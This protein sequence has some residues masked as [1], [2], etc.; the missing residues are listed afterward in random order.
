MNTST[1]P[2]QDNIP[3]LVLALK[4]RAL[5]LAATC[6]WVGLALFLATLPRVLRVPWLPA[7]TSSVAGHVGTHAVLA[8]LV[9]LA[10]RGPG[11]RPGGRQAALG[12]AFTVSLTLGLA[13]EVAQLALLTERGFELADIVDNLTGA[14]LGGLTVF[15][16]ETRGIPARRLQAGIGAISV[17]LISLA[18]VA[19]VVWDPRLPYR[20]D[21]WHALYSI[22]ICGDLLPAM[23]GTQGGVHTHGDGAIHIHPVQAAESGRNADLGL[24]F[25]TSGGELT[26][27]LLRLPGGRTVTNGDLCADGRPGKLSALVNGRQ[28][29]RPDRYVPRDRDTIEV[30]FG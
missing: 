9:Y 21:H 12:A 20:G 22:R 6:G 15:A 13:L 27:E 3:R 26:N 11:G 4:S 1:D 23:A 24:F 5:I 16:L 28:V 29:S 8:A 14:A 30:R 2:G 19:V 18:S 10:V 7:R 25:R 17:V